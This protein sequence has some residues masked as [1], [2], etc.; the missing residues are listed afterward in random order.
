[1]GGN[2]TLQ[3]ALDLAREEERVDRALLHLSSLQVDAVSSQPVQ[4]SAGM[5]STVGMTAGASSPTGCADTSTPALPTA[6]AGACYRC[7]SMQHWANSAACPARSRTCSRCGRHGH[8]ARVCRSTPE[9]SAARQGTETVTNTVTVLQVDKTVTTIGLLH[10]PIRINGYICN[11]LTDTG[12]AVSLL[13]VQD[14]KKYFAHIKL[15]PSHLILQNYSEQPIN[16]HGYFKASI[17]YNGN[18]A[19]IPF[20]VTDNGASLLGLDA[21]QALKL[22]IVGETLSC[23]SGGSSTLRASASLELDRPYAPMSRRVEDSIH[24]GVR[25]QGVPSVA[26]G[27][28]RRPCRAP[29]EVTGDHLQRDAAEV[30]RV[31]IVSGLMTELVNLERSSPRNPGKFARGLLHIVFSPHELKGKSLFG[32][33]CNAKKD[34]DDKKGL[35]LVRVKTVLASSDGPAPS[36]MTGQSSSD[37]AGTPSKASVTIV[38]TPVRKRKRNKRQQPPYDYESCTAEALQL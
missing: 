2:F 29:P 16:N 14:Y 6:R 27:L 10:L 28:H 18:C 15:V 7:G 12:A 24:R 3:K 26:A 36:L 20:F 35:D 1:M 21:S 5:A 13:S 9:S 17:S 38:A 25:R 11:M 30:G 22:I 8:F 33:K 37:S 23:S 34:H 19:M 4:D 31:D 32:R